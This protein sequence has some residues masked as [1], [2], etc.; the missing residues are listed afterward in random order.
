[1]SVSNPKMH[2]TAAETPIRS[3]VVKYNT[4]RSPEVVGTAWMPGYTAAHKETKA[5]A[6]EY[7]MNNRLE[8]IK[9][10]RRESEELHNMLTIESFDLVKP[11]R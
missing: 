11:S 3:W 1:M 6:I 4:G 7:A 10:L 2:L 5:E 9:A 8:Q